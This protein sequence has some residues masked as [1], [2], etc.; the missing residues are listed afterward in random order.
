MEGDPGAQAELGRLGVRQVPAV[1]VGDRVV[2]GWNPTAYAAL[3]G[4][5]YRPRPMLSPAELAERLD[6][7]LACGGR[8]AARIPAG[9]MGWTMPTRDRS[10][11]DLA[12]H[13]FRVGLSFADAMDGGEL[14]EGWFRERIPEDLADGAAVARY[15]ALVRGR[16][17][18]WFE[19]A[20]AGEFARD[21]KTY[22]GPQP[23]HELL[24]RTTWHVAQ[25]LR[26]LHHLLGELGL[27]PGEPS[28]S[29]LFERLPLP[30]SLW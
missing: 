29:A 9:R 19:G 25:H 14:P 15:G 28:P 1:A 6:Q 2:H 26:Q 27:D 17:Q 22:Y 4:V 12:F 3:L 21:V 18:G 30:E 5:E 23:A 11:G 7:L 13:L 16:L 10:L 20:G 8:L 24:E